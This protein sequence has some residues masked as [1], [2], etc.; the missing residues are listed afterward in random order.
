MTALHLTH[1]PVVSIQATL[2]SW[3]FLTY[4]FLI[5]SSCLWRA[6][7]YGVW[8]VH[9]LMSAVLCLLLGGRGQGM[10]F[11]NSLHITF[12]I[13]ALYLNFELEWLPAVSRESSLPHSAMRWLQTCTRLLMWMLESVIRFSGL[14]SESPPTLSHSSRLF[15]NS[16]YYCFQQHQCSYVWASLD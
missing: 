16:L 2:T 13:Q 4:I 5:V 11:S 3:I 8:I 9:M 7:I 12:V 14:L 10:F 1:N 6:W 15:F